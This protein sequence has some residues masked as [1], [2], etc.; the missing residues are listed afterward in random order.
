ML[1]DET[2]DWYSEFLP[3]YWSLLA[4]RRWAA[5]ICLASIFYGRF[6]KSHEYGH[7]AG[8]RHYLDHACKELEG[9]HHG[10]LLR[11]RALQNCKAYIKE[12]GAVL[13]LSD[14]E[15][16]IK[17]TI[18]MRNQP[19]EEVVEP[20][21]DI[22]NTH[23]NLARHLLHGE[24]GHS[25][26]IQAPTFIRRDDPGALSSALLTLA[27][28]HYELLTQ[29]PSKAENE[30]ITPST[31]R[32]LATKAEAQSRE[33]TLNKSKA[34][35]L[36]S[37]CFLEEKNISRALSVSEMAVDHSR[38]L[39]SSDGPTPNTS[40]PPVSQTAHLTR[41][42]VALVTYSRCQQANDQ[43]EEA[44][45]SST[46]A[47]LILRL[48]LRDGQQMRS[49]GI[50]LRAALELR[51]DIS[52]ALKR[53]D[54]AIRDRGESFELWLR[55]SKQGLDCKDIAP[56]FRALCLSGQYERAHN[57]ALRAENLRFSFMHMSQT[58]PNVYTNPKSPLLMLSEICQSEIP[59]S[60]PPGDNPP[61]TPA[62]EAPEEAEA[63][64]LQSKAKALQ[65]EAK[66]YEE[67]ETH[68]VEAKA[69]KTKANTLHAEAKAL[70][71]K[72]NALRA[73][74]NALKQAES[75]AL[76]AIDFH[77]QRKPTHTEVHDADLALSRL[78]LSDVLRDQNRYLDALSCAKEAEGILRRHLSSADE[79]FTSELVSHLERDLLPLGKSG[80]QNSGLAAGEVDQLCAYLSASIA[81]PSVLALHVALGLS[82]E[83]VVNSAGVRQILET[84]QRAINLYPSVHSG[85]C[86]HFW[87]RLSGIL[88]LIYRVHIEASR[89]SS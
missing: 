18:Q 21:L 80:D 67:A 20:D 69:R 89:M 56:F 15:S 5:I 32:D 76:Q 65:E 1:H 57:E 85:K 51:A 41:L 22:I 71:A 17:A 74:A 60:P 40:S 37:K 30:S 55:H 33:D 14:A 2:T 45:A 11:D 47:I 26:E 52:D 73:K 79:A 58:P 7:F 8:A 88:D 23:T 42:S 3:K 81:S 27:Q 4:K 70:E 12:A 19:E 68:Q 49:T 82:Q 75:I 38:T 39:V 63:K 16:I 10:N 50:H 78:C 87:D 46:E 28:S 64:V 35:D 9:G 77:R 25:S 59:C 13:N 43:R 6:V 24:L 48:L 62:L 53:P 83:S 66:T 86:R 44:L 31:I 84:H 29:Y 34:L 72:V 54:E 36:I 61:E